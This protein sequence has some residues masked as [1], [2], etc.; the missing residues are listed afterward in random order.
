MR[1][2]VPK[3]D[4]ERQGT[5]G[6]DRLRLRYPQTRTSSDPDILRPRHSQIQVLVS[7][8]PPLVFGGVWNRSLP[9]A[10]ADAESGTEFFGVQRNLRISDSRK[11]TR[12]RNFPRATAD[13][14]G[15]SGSSQKGTEGTDFPAATA[16]AYE[17]QCF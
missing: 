5:L 17:K 6:T 7:E 4:R 14:S 9:A 10:T 15:P 3:Q 2:Q 8:T 12:E 13:A 16:D 1:S 11:G